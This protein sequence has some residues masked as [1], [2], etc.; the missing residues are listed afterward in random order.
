MKY[1]LT[2]STAI[3]LL[4]IFGCNSPKSGKTASGYQYV[5]HTNNSGPKATDGYIV[6]Y[7]VQHR[8]KNTITFKSRIGDRPP[9][10]ILMPDFTTPTEKGSPIME[11]LRMMTEGDSATVFF[12]LS[13]KNIR[14]KGFED[15][16]FMEYDVV[17]DKM[18][19]GDQARLLEIQ[20]ELEG[21]APPTASTL[22]IEGITKPDADPNSNDAGVIEE[23]SDEAALENLRPIINDFKAGK[24]DTKIRT[25]NSQLKIY[26]FGQGTGKKA[27]IGSFAHVH[28]LGV[29]PDGKKFDASFDRGQPYKFV[30]GKREAITGWDEGI[31]TLNEGGKALL[32]IPSHLAYG[33]KGVPQAGI[34]PNTDLFFYVHL[35]KVE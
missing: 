1:P 32:Y 20:R 10:V 6:H 14:P 5:N 17:I 9:M 22:T 23:S 26:L 31:A 2:I 19:K 24:L 15:A 16:E 4:S 35:T 34:L 27:K 25:T 12:P 13:N 7:H 30:L 33:E 11:V 8:N 29:L 3:F 21:V 28:Y 18:E